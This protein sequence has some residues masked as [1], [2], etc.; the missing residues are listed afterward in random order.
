MNTQPVQ[1][2]C[3]ECKSWLDQYYID[4]P[5]LQSWINSLEDRVNVLTKEN[6]RLLAN[7]KRQKTTGSIFFK[8]VEAA[9]AI[10]NSKIAW[11]NQIPEPEVLF[12]Q[13]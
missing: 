13:K 6:N 2:Q 8:N 1:P 11:S 4:V 9:I 5:L 7:Y 12:F 3:N 10:V